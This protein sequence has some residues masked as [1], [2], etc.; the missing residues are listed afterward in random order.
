V[1]VAFVIL[2]VAVTA[3]RAAGHRFSPQRRAIFDRSIEQIKGNDTYVINKK[4]HRTRYQHVSEASRR[5]PHLKAILCRKDR[6][7]TLARQ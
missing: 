5:W 7:Q 2:H 3:M 6:E 4:R 1:D